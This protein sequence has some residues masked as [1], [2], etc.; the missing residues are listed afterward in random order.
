MKAP[1]TWRAPEYYFREKGADWY[2]AVG[3]ISIS[4][5]ATAIILDNVLFGLLVIIAA[6]SL[7]IYASRRPAIADVEINEKGVKFGKMFYP[8][9]N[10][11]S[12]WV[13]ETHAYPKILLK[14]KKVFV[15]HIVIHLEDEDPEEV[16]GFLRE[17]LPEVEQ[18]EPLMQSI[19]EYLGF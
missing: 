18:A 6:L 3:I 4:V 5:T 7:M 8:F 14:S 13:E 1:I 16:R 11:D 19:M 17:H 2:W 15:S 10:L 9:S 12:F